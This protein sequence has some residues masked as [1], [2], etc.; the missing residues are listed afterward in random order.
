MKDYCGISQR[1]RP[2]LVIIIIII[3]IVIIIIKNF[4]YFLKILK[5]GYLL[6]QYK[7]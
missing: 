3:I 7:M 1:L 6:Q 4:G 5:T 2:V